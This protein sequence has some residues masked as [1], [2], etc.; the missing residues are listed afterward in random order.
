MDGNYNAENVYFD[1]DLIT[2]SAVGNIT[3][4]NGSATIAAAG[5]N[6]K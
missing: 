5:K 1:E 6:L 3:L 2:T 4:T